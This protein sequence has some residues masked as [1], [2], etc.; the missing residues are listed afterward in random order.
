M[1]Y[2]GLP[3][4]LPPLLP[5]PRSWRERS[6]PTPPPPRRRHAAATACSDDSDVSGHWRDDRRSSHRCCQRRGLGSGRGPPSHVPHAAYAGGDQPRRAAPVRHLR[7][8]RCS[9]HR[10]HGRRPVACAGRRIRVAG[11]VGTLSAAPPCLSPPCCEL[12][13]QH[14]TLMAVH[15]K[16]RPGQARPGQARPVCGCF[17]FACL[18]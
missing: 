4:A 6:T 5:L 15:A 2:P 9:W 10:L 1:R 18:Y 3:Q 12:V 8:G 13:T 14:T 7:P 17:V 11:R 16:A